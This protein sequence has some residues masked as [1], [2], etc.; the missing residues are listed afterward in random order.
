MVINF[1]SRQSR[2]R[3]S[4]DSSVSVKQSIIKQE[5]LKGEILKEIDDITKDLNDMIN[6]FGMKNLPSDIKVG[7]T[8]SYMKNLQDVDDHLNSLKLKEIKIQEH[9]IGGDEEQKLL[10]AG[11]NWMVEQSR[12][13]LKDKGLEKNTKKMYEK[14]RDDKKELGEHFASLN[15]GVKGYS[16]MFTRFEEKGGDPKLLTSDDKLN[17]L[18]KTLI[19]PLNNK[20]FIKAAHEIY[21]SL[22]SNP[23]QTIVNSRICGLLKAVKNSVKLYN[24]KL[25]TEIDK[26]ITTTAITGR[27]HCH[28]NTGKQGK[29]NGG[30]GKSKSKGKNKGKKI[31]QERKV[32]KVVDNFT[33]INKFL[34]NK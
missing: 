15:V 25:V 10:G 14:L 28:P 22:G 23:N 30:T 27:L 24:P 2:S 6:S 8:T 31:N 16:R 9:R 13:E 4:N 32:K 29:D 5:G 34:Q 19:N 12:K 33:I 1:G 7:G 20:N 17:K 18:A 3:S 26:I 21:K 11:F